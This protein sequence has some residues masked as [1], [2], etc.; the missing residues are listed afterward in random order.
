MT[1]AEVKKL[2]PIGEVMTINEF[3]NCVECGGFIPY[4]GYGYYFDAKKKTET[5][6][7]VSFDVETLLKK[8][9]KYKHVIWYNR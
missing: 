3:I 1:K 6:E 8:A 9:G 7:E 4:D 5:K 2:F